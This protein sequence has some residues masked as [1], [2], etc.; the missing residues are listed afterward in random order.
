MLFSSGEVRFCDI[1]CQSCHI[2]KN[3][4]LNSQGNCKV[5]DS[6]VQMYYYPQKYKYFVTVLQ[7]ISFASYILTQ[8]PVLFYVFDIFQ[9]GLLL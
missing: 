7:K 3:C 8:A 5:R 4:E 1:Y 9:T 2:F 6:L